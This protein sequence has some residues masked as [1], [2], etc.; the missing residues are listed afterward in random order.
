M[1]NNERSWR[2]KEASTDENVQ[3]V[4]SQI[5]SDRRRSLRDIAKHLS[6]GI[7]PVQFILTNILRMSKVSARWGPNYDQRS[8]EELAGYF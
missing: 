6:I 3:L 1:E 2:P 5:M 8:Q 7:G 4:L